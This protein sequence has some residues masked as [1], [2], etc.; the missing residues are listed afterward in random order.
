MQEGEPSGIESRQRVLEV[1]GGL[2]S[3]EIP[4]GEMVLE[5]GALSGRLV[6]LLEGSLEVIRDGN[7]VGR[8]SAPGSV[9]GA[10]S[11]LMGDPQIEGV[12]TL[13]PCRVVR[14]GS[15]L[16][17]LEQHPGIA[18]HLAWLL[19]G[20]LASAVRFLVDAQRQYSGQGGQAAMTDRILNLL[21]HR[22][23]RLGVPDRKDI[24]PDH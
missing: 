22:Y 19:A 10:V 11:A 15:P 8:E 17:F 13:G 12:R 21:V 1:A 18:L 3:E 6:F 20:R 14:I 9:F 7:V 2:P 4:G 23:P 16:P 5:Q 24:R